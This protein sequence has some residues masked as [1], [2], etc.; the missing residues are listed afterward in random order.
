MN[1]EEEFQMPWKRVDR[2][3]VQ[4]AVHS[5]CLSLDIDDLDVARKALG[6]LPDKRKITSDDKMRVCQL[7]AEKPEKTR[8]L[9]VVADFLYPYEYRVD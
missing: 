4:H 1:K 2:L 3:A 9:L 8:H 5:R 6:L 7:I